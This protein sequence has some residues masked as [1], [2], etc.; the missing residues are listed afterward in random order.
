VVVIRQFRPKRKKGWPR[1]REEGPTVTVAV[2]CGSGRIRS[3]RILSS[4]VLFLFFVFS[5][6]LFGL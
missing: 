5:G 2:T 4:P 1:D 6:V 3:S